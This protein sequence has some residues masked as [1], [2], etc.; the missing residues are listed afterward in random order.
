M[1]WF[2]AS[3]TRRKFIKYSGLSVLSSALMP[4]P[5]WKDLQQEFPDA[6]RLGRICVGKVE[7]RKKPSVDAE[8]VGT[9]YEDSI[10]VWLREVIGQVPRGR[11]SARW[12]ETP[13]GYIYSPNVQPVR[14]QPNVP[15]ETMPETE[16]GRGM[17]IEITTPQT[18]VFLVG[19]EARSGWLKY[20]I[21]TYQIPKLYY[22]QVIWV[23]DIKTGEAGEK[24]YRVNEKFGYGD[25]FWIDAAACRPITAEEIAPILPESENKRVVIDVSTNR[26]ILSCYDGK[27]EIY[28]CVI[29]SGA[30]WNSEG[31][32]VREWGTPVGENQRTW[33]KLISI[34]MSGGE[35]GAGYDLPGVGWTN[36]F[37]GTG[38]AIHSTFWHNDFGTP[39]S[40][41][42]INCAPDDAKFVFRFTNPQI[43]LIPGDMTVGMPGGTGVY[44]YEV[45]QT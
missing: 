28:S 9:L 14:N 18:P 43:P 19:K 22:S 44:V 39:R 3:L 41:G 6:E 17:W 21:E 42:C 35:S 45:G 38:V 34:H 23:D 10:V 4:K 24:L 5:I 33:R 29:S 25:I 11:Q 20:A 13:D 7:V 12:V 26:Q 32:I 8:S 2:D 36:L 1:K 27:N 40:H 31:Q 16:I 37:A 15:L 30:Y